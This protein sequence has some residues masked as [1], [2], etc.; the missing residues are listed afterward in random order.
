MPAA[1]PPIVGTLRRGL[2]LD[3]ASAIGFGT[4][5]GYV[6]WY[7]FHLRRVRERDVFYSRLEAQRD[8]ERA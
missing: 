7:G 2:V 3:V 4:T 5:A 8:A 1:V 6:W